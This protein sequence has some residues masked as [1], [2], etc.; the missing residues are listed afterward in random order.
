MVLNDQSSRESGRVSSPSLL[1]PV[2]N[3]SVL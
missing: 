3:T 1:W 2:V